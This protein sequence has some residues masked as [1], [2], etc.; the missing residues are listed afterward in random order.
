MNI[1]ESGQVELSVL[2]FLLGQVSYHPRTR[3]LGEALGK[4]PV[5]LT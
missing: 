5:T 1:Q 3:K 4:D 2:A